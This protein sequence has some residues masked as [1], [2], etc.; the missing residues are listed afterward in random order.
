[1]F[2][3][4]AITEGINEILCY[5]KT[6]PRPDFATREIQK[7]L[8]EELGIPAFMIIIFTEKV[9]GL[10]VLERVKNE[11]KPRKPYPAMYAKLI[12]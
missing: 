9:K 6:F 11:W 1:M 5:G 10:S 2:K 12:S 4:T 8:L 3:T 7:V